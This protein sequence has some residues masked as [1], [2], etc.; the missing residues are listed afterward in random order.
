GE[1][2]FGD[3]DAGGKAVAFTVVEARPPRTFSFRWTH[4]ADEAAA[5]GNSLLVTFDLAPAGG[6][7]LLRMTE[8]GFREMGWEVAVLEQQYQEHVAG[9]DHFLPRLAPYVA[10]LLVRRR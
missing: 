7:T 10:T 3:C 6:G 4:P 1:I 5:V 9:W 2:V 8:T